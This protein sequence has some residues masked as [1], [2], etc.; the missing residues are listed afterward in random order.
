[1]STVTSTAIPASGPKVPATV[2]PPSPVRGFRCDCVYGDTHSTKT[3]RLGD[4]AEWFWKRTGKPSRLIS[5]DPGGW[6]S[7]QHLADKGII[8]PFKLIAA[9]DPNFPDAP[10]GRPHLLEDM[11]KLAQGYWPKD[12]KNPLSPL[13][14]PKLDG[15]AALLID[16]VTT[17][18][19]RMMQYYEVNI[20]ITGEGENA[21]MRATNV[22]VPEMP[23][24]SFVKDGTYQKRFTGRSDYKGVQDSIKKFIFDSAMLP[25]PVIWTALEEKGEDA[26]GKPTYG[27]KFT[28]SALTGVCG[29]WFGNMIHLDKIASTS[30][31]VDPT[32]PTGKSKIA[33]IEAR[34]IMFLKNH[35]DPN[36][37]YKVVY[38]AG[39]RVVKDLYA[40]VP[41]AAKPDLGA[42]FDLLEKLREEA[43]ATRA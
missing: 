10:A 34:P 37:P 22:R 42:L 33:V 26:Q 11:Q 27:P 2:V 14:A 36:D 1:M 8:I 29:P 43:G 25:V 6:E 5:S 39:V 9:N 23:K 7:I 4:A 18:C 40:K 12:P 3:S 20:K 32:D 17:W 24:D 35:I 41:L 28:G 13:E 21:V 38:P 15:I 30:E 19:E 31:M 16:G